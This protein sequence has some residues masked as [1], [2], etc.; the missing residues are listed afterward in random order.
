MKHLLVAAA[1]ALTLAACADGGSSPIE[2]RGPSLGVGDRSEI[3]YGQTPDTTLNASPGWEVAT[4]FYATT[5]GCIRQLHFY[6]ASGE[7]GTNEVHV[8]SESGT[9]L[10]SGN[11]AYSGTGWHTLFLEPRVGPPIDNS[12]CFTSAYTYFRV[13][14]NTNSKQGKT[15]GYFDNGEVVNGALRADWS[16]YGS[17]VGS[18]PTTGSGSGYFV[19]VTFEEQ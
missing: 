3:F 14:V 11:I 16:F 13:S 18:F 2:P 4:R 9:E 5:P 12:I 15:F 17:S 8:W 1:A 10:Y 7:T 19:D 6:R